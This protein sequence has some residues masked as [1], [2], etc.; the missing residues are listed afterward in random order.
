MIKMGVDRHLGVL[1]KSANM[2]VGVGPV[3][4]SALVFPLSAGCRSDSRNFIP[5]L[6]NSMVSFPFLLFTGLQKRQILVCENMNE[7]T[8]QECH[9]NTCC[10]PE[11]TDLA[12]PMRS[13][14]DR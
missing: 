3:L 11:D 8:K 7:C 6:V 10:G 4:Q 14:G 1:G 2:G 5:T 9:P 13:A 12:V